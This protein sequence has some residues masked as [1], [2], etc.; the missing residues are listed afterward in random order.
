M[1]SS[2]GNRCTHLAAHSSKRLNSLSI[3]IL[4]CLGNTH[5]NKTARQT[6]SSLVLLV[7]TFDSY[8]W[9]GPISSIT[10][11]NVYT[12]RIN[13]TAQTRNS[14]VLWWLLWYQIALN[15]SSIFG[16]SENVS[17]QFFPNYVLNISRYIFW[18][19]LLWV[20]IITNYYKSPLKVCE[21]KVGV[22]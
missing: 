4:V 18:V 20:K 5:K 11:S 3:I 13:N 16:I 9:I 14:T 21:L 10:S 17:K 7:K 19:R 2:W 22:K 6:A 8:W 1:C 12:K 15:N